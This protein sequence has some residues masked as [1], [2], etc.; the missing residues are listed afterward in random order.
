MHGKSSLLV[1]LI[2]CVFVSGCFDKTNTVNNNEIN[3]IIPSEPNPLKSNNNKLNELLS[4]KSKIENQALIETTVK[5]SLGFE[6]SDAFLEIYNGIWEGQSNLENAE[7]IAKA[8]ILKS[9]VFILEIGQQPSSFVRIDRVLYI[10][11]IE[12]MMSGVYSSLEGETDVVVR[13][14]RNPRE[15]FL[16]I[17]SDTSGTNLGTVTMTRR[18][19]RN[20]LTVSKLASAKL[21]KDQVKENSD[22]LIDDK[23]N[24]VAYDKECILSSSL[25]DASLNE[26]LIEVVAK[27]EGDCEGL[28]VGEFYGVL[29]LTND[30]DIELIT[31]SLNNAA[32]ANTTIKIEDIYNGG[33]LNAL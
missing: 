32:V 4:I 1:T 30:G 29:G 17:D 23:G 28:N 5:D 11:D 16:F 14:R 27:T 15:I 12:Y 3:P 7:G 13:L 18:P 31:V 8:T 26:G 9:G 22:L 24:F 10:T 20:K 2:L 6:H 33:F 21:V 19:L 25:T